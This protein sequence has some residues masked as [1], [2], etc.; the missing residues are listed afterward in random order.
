MKVTVKAWICASPSNCSDK[1][2]YNVFSFDP[3]K[4]EKAN[5]WVVVKSFEQEV[6]VDENIDLR[7]ELVKN[8]E[9]ERQ[10]LRADFQNRITQ[11]ERQIS[12]LTA[13]GCEVS[14]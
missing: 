7:P 3:T 1:P 11:I 13:I 8:L 6:E 9:R 14:A 4:M 5:D 10:Q 12:E 2:F